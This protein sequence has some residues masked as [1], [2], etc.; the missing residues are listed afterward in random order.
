MKRREF[1]TQSVGVGA[2]SVLAPAVAL[3]TNHEDVAHRANS[4]A[5]RL[6]KAWF[7]SLLDEQ[8]LFHQE[9]Q[10]PSAARLVAIQV[11]PGSRK[12]EQFSAVFRIM[13]GNSLGGLFEAEHAKVGRFPLY[14][15]PGTAFSA[16]QMC[17]AHFSLLKQP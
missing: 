12:H 2:A 7:E 16:Q 10:E 11:I 15:S 5:Q 1:F 17:L 9:G 4:T 6:S 14:V 13:K 8:F 3:A